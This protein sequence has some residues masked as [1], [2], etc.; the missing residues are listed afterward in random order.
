MYV[1]VKT[2]R[3]NGTPHELLEKFL[4]LFFHLL[5]FQLPFV[6]IYKMFRIAP[7]HVISAID[8]L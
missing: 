2:L 5:I 6:N 8:D 7:G 3:T 4:V 1:L